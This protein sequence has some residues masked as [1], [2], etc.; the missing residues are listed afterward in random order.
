[1][2]ARLPS[3]RGCYERFA[4]LH[5]EQASVAHYLQASHPSNPCA[6]SGFQT[7]SFEQVFQYR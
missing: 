7:D 6:G 1:M 5:T 2:S 3:Y 4:G